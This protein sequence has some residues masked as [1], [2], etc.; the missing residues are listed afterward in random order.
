VGDV[1]VGGGLLVW[2]REQKPKCGQRHHITPY[3]SAII[4][5]GC[6]QEELKRT[7]ARIKVVSPHDWRLCTPDY[8]KQVGRR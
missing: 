7:W 6:S 2:V 4:I 8:F 5:Q 3:D 1:V